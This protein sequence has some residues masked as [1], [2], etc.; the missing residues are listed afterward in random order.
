M[1]SNDWEEDLEKTEYA[2][3]LLSTE[4]VEI[5]NGVHRIE[6][7]YCLQSNE[8]KFMHLFTRQCQRDLW[9]EVYNYL[10][11]N[12]DSHAMITGNPGVGKSRSMSY[13]LRLLLQKKRTV[14]YEVRKDSRVYAFIP[15]SG[16]QQSSKYKVWSCSDKTFLPDVCTPLMNSASY[17]LID[18]DTPAPILCGPYHTS[19]IVLS[20]SPNR[21]HFKEFLKL[22]RTIT[23]CMPIWKKEELKAIQPYFE[24]EKGVKLTDT[25]FEARYFDFGGRIR[26][27]YATKQKYDENWG[28]LRNSVRNLKLPRLIKALVDEVIEMTQSDEET[29]SILFVYDMMGLEK[30]YSSLTY[31]YLEIEGNVRLLIGSERIRQLLCANYWNEIMNTL[32]PHSLMYSGNATANGRLFELVARVYLEFAMNLDALD[33]VEK[34]IVQKLQL[35]EGKRREFVGT[36]E[37]YLVECSKLPTSSNLTTSREILIP[38]AINQPVIDMM[39]ACDRA[40]QFTVG[41]KHSVN[42]KRLEQII[43]ILKVT[44]KKPLTLYFVIPEVILKEFKWNYEGEFDLEDEVKRV[45]NHTVEK[46]KNEL[47]QLGEFTSGKKEELI[48]RLLD[49]Q[50]VE[51]ETSA[52]MLNQLEQNVQIFILCIPRDPNLR[53]QEMIQRIHEK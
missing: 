43:E 13:L 26:Y 9:N 40:Y 11:R 2:N 10:E 47:K 25:E 24:I 29:P 17:R 51:G 48:R 52:E 22:E 3:A 34:E 36:W 30:T 19:H 53:I 42:V 15:P 23:W 41:K 38:K 7:K 12:E 32:D 37:E 6:M 18:P 49:A 33:A 28:A 14:V 50:G 5:S 45:E 8:K 16:H 1:D 31:K 35:P 4:E 44:P 20:A 27:V 46:L 39:D 21:A